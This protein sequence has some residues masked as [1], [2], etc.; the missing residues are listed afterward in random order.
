MLARLEAQNLLNETSE[1]KN[2]G[3]IMGLYIKF[4][5]D[6]RYG[7]LLEDDEEETIAPPEFTWTP[8]NFDHYINAYAT[9]FGIT[10][11]GPSNIDGLTAEMDTDLLLPT[12]GE[13]WDWDTAFKS[14]Q[15]RYA[16]S[17]PMGRQS[18]PQIG[19]DNLDIT[20]WSSAERKGYSFSK[21]DPLK[22]ADLKA[23][24]EGMVMNIG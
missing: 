21:K 3:L 6:M 23:L 4:S 15:K 8:S 7:S 10:L 19:G 14:Y 18:K 24:K 13:S 17:P 11:H 20:T 22:A 12:A 1:I 16:T 5:A 9:K 2:L